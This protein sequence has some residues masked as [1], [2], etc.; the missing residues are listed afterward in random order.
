[1]LVMVLEAVRQIAGT[2]QAI[3]GICL[4][5]VRFDKALLVPSTDRGVETNLFLRKEKVE[6]GD[7]SVWSTFRICSY[8]NS[9]WVENC[10]GSVSV[11][12]ESGQAGHNGIK[13]A[14]E[15][16]EMKE[17]LALFHTCTSRC[18]NKVNT[19]QLYDVLR[20]S[21]YQFGETFQVLHEAKF[22]PPNLSSTLIDPTDIVNKLPD[23]RVQDHLIHPTT[24][25][26]VLQ[27]VSVILTR[28]GEKSI[29]SVYPTQIQELWISGHFNS[30]SKARRIMTSTT[31]EVKGFRTV[32]AAISVMDVANDEICISIEGFRATSHATLDSSASDQQAHRRLSYQV[33]W[34]ADI[35]LLGHDQLE[36]FCFAASDGFRTPCTSTN[37][38][39]ELACLCFM[40][41]AVSQVAAA[42]V[43]CSTPHLQKY[44]QWMEHQVRQPQESSWL[45]SYLQSNANM[46]MKHDNGQAFVH[47][48]NEDSNAKL[49]CT[50][51]RKLPAILRGEMDPLDLLFNTGLAPDA[52]QHL[53]KTDPNYPRVTA[54][55]DA[56]AHK[57]PGMRILEI[58]AGTGGTTEPV[59]RALS[60][61]EPNA[62]GVPR[63][64]EYTFTDISPSFFEKA[65]SR[66][67]EWSDRMVFNV[68]DVEKDPASQGYEPEA[69]DLVIAANVIG[70]HG[71]LSGPTLTCQQQVLHAT[72]NLS[73]TAQNTRRLLKPFVKPS[74]F[75]RIA[76]S[77]IIPSS[78]GKLI[79]LEQTN[80]DVRRLSFAFGILP[81][82]WLSK[83]CRDVSGLQRGSLVTQARK[84]IACGRP[85]LRNNAGMKY[86]LPMGSLGLT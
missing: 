81:G 4:K 30:Y 26:G 44:Y 13:E 51:G 56:I 78:G 24:L 39:L 7:F 5:N 3:E 58:G 18:K 76:S 2:D 38:E 77:N 22:G 25:D 23:Y 35:D 34:K 17:R 1:M 48:A 53:A 54:Y 83:L 6:E 46:R 14:T 73:T 20:D 62:G 28:G 57:N 71:S 79:L 9:E 27:S 42:E 61:Q 45:H 80:L 66:F 16:E 15:K 50:V 82:W 32:E 8:H 29:S 40:E 11:Q 85:L 47:L 84:S 68:L 86:C 49:I 70:S 63:F 10:T 72:A 65:R 69:Y 19:S 33:G 41:Q 59:L 12:Y 52:Y 75:H 36:R 60:H 55:L 64:R 31:A 21:G 67:Q 37:Q 43:Q 74:T